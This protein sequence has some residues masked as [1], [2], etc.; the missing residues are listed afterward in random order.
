MTSY[1]FDIETTGLDPKENKIITIQYQQLEMFSGRPIS[2]LIILKEWESSEK[3]ILEKFINDT[4]ICGGN[5]FAFVP[6][7]FNL[8]FE[9]N[10]LKVRTTIN[11]LPEIDILNKPFIDLKAIGVLM[12][13]GQFKGSG[14]DKLTGKEENGSKIPIYYE[15]KEYEKIVR[16]IEQET[17]EFLKFSS[18]LYEKMPKLL[19]EFKTYT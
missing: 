13:G 16:Y 15:N 12:N 9:H 18:W 1:Y 8:G 17:K 4:Q 2:D 10:F 5:D 19:K 6:T 3:E 11:G 7:G 14:L